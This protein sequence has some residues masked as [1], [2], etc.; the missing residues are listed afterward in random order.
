MLQSNVQLVN[1]R[2]RSREFCSARRSGNRGDHKGRDYHYDTEYHY[3][4]EQA[5][6]VSFVACDQVHTHRLDSM[7]PFWY[8]PIVFSPRKG[9][10]NVTHDFRESSA[11][12][13]ASS[14]VAFGHSGLATLGGLR[15]ATF[16]LRMSFK[17]FARS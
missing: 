12:S 5:E 8:S 9:E 13:Y 15:N 6:S 2:E 11:Q 1:S 3:Q 17:L 16:T 7:P 14:G 10:S 4:F